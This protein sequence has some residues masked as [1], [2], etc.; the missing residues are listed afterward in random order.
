MTLDDLAVGALHDLAEQARPAPDAY[1]R[2]VRR[3]RRQRRRKQAVVLMAVTGLIAALVVA[4]PGG[5]APPV[6]HLDAQ[7]TW[8]HRLVDSPVRGAVATGDPAYV[9]VLAD[10]IAERQNDGE[11]AAKFQVRDARVLYVDDIGDQRI[12]FAALELDE[13]DP[14]TGT[15][16]GAAWFEG[17][18]GVDPDRL[19]DRDAVSNTAVGLTPFVSNQVVGGGENGMPL[20]ALAPAECVVSAAAWPALIEWQPEPTGSYL[21]RTALRSEWWRVTCAGTI[22]EEVPA[23][24]ASDVSA[25]PY[26]DDQ[27]QGAR[28][29]PD[30]QLARQKL[31]AM[32][33]MEGY[34]LSSLPRLLWG[35]RITWPEDPR[36]PGTSAAGRTVV[37][38]AP[39]IRGG[40]AGSVSL[41]LDDPG[42]DGPQNWEFQAYFGRDPTR[43]D[44]ITA[45]RLAESSTV[46]V[47]VPDAAVRVR[48]VHGGVAVAQAPV[49]DAAALVTG[50]DP[51]TATFEALDGAGRVVGTTALE[52]RP[53]DASAAGWSLP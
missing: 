24:A 26:P 3:Y 5:G 44:A 53:P 46:L 8:V 7:V 29:T 9:R 25:A 11:Y 19:A 21:V 2:V 22:R 18:R 10:T 50:M 12:A 28:G 34:A 20:V 49:V 36:V 47:I 32:R 51:E 16:Y 43:P 23:P 17:R 30:H 4:V 31:A 42:D 38:A 41:T 27:L 13:P 15:R 35:G 45:V 33:G 6:Q 1:G 52:L 37:V 14:V 40:W 39:L 48:A